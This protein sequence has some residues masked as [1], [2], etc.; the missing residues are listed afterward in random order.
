MRCSLS[1]LTNDQN[2]RPEPSPTEMIRAAKCGRSDLSANTHDSRKGEKPHSH[3][4]GD[5]HGR[6]HT[7]THTHVNSVSRRRNFTAARCES[8]NLYK[9]R[10]RA[11][12]P[13]LCVSVSLRL[14]VPFPKLWIETTPP[15]GPPLRSG[16]AQGPASPHQGPFLGAGCGGGAMP[17]TE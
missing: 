6:R 10:I 15:G 1:D 11:T 16:V 8:G 12:R 9:D 14:C 4:N 2:G 13:L 7:H 17:L 5:T 3:T